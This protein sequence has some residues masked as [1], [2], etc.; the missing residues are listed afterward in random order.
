MNSRKLNHARSKISP[1]LN[2]A[3]IKAKNERKKRQVVKKSLNKILAMDAGTSVYL[4][5]SRP[6]AFFEIKCRKTNFF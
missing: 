4:L 1:I 5:P 3:D 6:G 2:T